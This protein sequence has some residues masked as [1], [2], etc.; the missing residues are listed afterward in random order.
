MYL[1]SE[2]CAVCQNATSLRPGMEGSCEMVAL[3][4]ETRV[5]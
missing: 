3:E 4:M 2:S 1:G 5:S